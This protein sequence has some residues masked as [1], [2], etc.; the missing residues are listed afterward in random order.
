MVA[1]HSTFYQGMSGNYD[2]LRYKI[3]LVM[4][5]GAVV[6]P[7]KIPVYASQIDIAATLLYQL[8]LPH[9]EFKF[10]KNILNPDSPH[11]GYFTN[12]NLFGMIT[13]GNQLGY[14]CDLHS[15]TGDYGNNKGENLKK[16]KALLQVLY[17]DLAIR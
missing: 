12:N 17:D 9:D 15:V 16:G 10:S 4:A 3:P 13:A 14:D 7:V 8:G 6:R 5:G 1:D 2:T 11:F